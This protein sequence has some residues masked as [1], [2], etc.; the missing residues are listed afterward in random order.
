[1]PAGL[2]PQRVEVWD[3][4]TGPARSAVAGVPLRDKIEIAFDGVGEGQRGIGWRADA[5]ATS[6]W[7]GTQDGGDPNHDAE[8]QD[9]AFTLNARGDA[10]IVFGRRPVR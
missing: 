1:M 10:P 3:V 4:Q 6:C 5:D 2:F 7:T 8:I 9:C